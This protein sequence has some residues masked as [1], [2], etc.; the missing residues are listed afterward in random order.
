MK[1]GGGMEYTRKIKKWQKDTEPAL[2][3]LVPERLP[4]CQVLRKF[5]NYSVSSLWLRKGL[6]M[7]PASNP[8]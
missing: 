7:E 1:K 2:V 4:V 6:C 5:I 8:H 3:P